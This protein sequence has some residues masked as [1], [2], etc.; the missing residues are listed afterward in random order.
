MSC[1]LGKCGWINQIYIAINIWGCW[2]R[3][4]GRY[5]WRN[6]E[7]WELEGH[8]RAEGGKLGCGFRNAC[9]PQRELEVGGSPA[10]VGTQD[11]GPWIRNTCLSYWRTLLL[12]TPSSTEYLRCCDPKLINSLKIHVV[13][14][15]CLGKCYGNTYGHTC[16]HNQTHFQYKT[17]SINILRFAKLC[18]HFCVCLYMI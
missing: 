10:G 7:I 17:S 4:D 1:N 6:G 15:V 9:R 11:D 3:K 2:E 14:A 8:H 13:R 5:E 16:T 18:S 12:R